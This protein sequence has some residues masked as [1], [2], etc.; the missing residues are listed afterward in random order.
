MDG[1]RETEKIGMDGENDRKR[2][3]MIRFF[4]YPI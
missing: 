1:W 2:E 4:V 3:R